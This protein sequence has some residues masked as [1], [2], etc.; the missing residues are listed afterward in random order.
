MLGGF[1]KL[2]T[3]LGGSGRRKISQLKSIF[4]DRRLFAAQ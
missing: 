4:T 3:L 2:H 1:G